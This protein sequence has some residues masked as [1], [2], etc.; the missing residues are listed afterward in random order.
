M[1]QGSG[2]E[3]NQQ[4]TMFA[5]WAWRPTTAPCREPRLNRCAKDWRRSS[6]RGVLRAGLS[7][8]QLAAWTRLSRQM[9][10]FIETNRRVPTIDQREDTDV[11][12]MAT[13]QDALMGVAG[14]EVYGDDCELYEQMG[15]KCTSE[16]SSGLSRKKQ[17][18][19]EK[20]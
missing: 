20:Q 2:R 6:R 10:S 14:D 19:P 13:V 18:Q 7:L 4:E 11:V 16:Y 9:L 1:G 3:W 12:S 5:W 8:T 15:R 17:A